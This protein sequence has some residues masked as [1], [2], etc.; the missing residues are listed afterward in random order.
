MVGG[1]IMGYLGG[2]HFWWPKITGRK[3]VESWGK[4]S[5]LL[6][7]VGFNLPFFP[8]FV[9]GYLGLAR[10][11]HGDPAGPNPGGAP[12]LEWTTQSPPLP[13]NF[14]QVPV[15]TEEPYDHTRP[16]KEAVRV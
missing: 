2:L 12:G 3:Y 15:V 9:L 16:P 1:A 6:I 13:H 7:F 11:R 8:Q 5:S 14:D 10:R 4:V